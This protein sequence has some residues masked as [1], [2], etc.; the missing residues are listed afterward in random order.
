MIS[1]IFSLICLAIPTL[2]QSINITTAINTHNKYRNLHQVGNV[3]WNSSIANHSQA[4]VNNCKFGHDPTGKYGE[5]IYA[6]W[7][8]SPKKDFTKE[9]IKLW[10]D[11]V[12]YYNFSRPGFS[13]KTGHF[14]QVVWKNTKQIGC[15]VRKCPDGMVLISCQ[16]NPPG[17]YL[18]QFRQNVFPAKTIKSIT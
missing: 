7:G 13:G 2:T 15:G 4:W 11:E 14:T 3:T 17:N 8:Y 16:Y 6:S 9:A 10:Y 18:G 1:Y 12:K 5:N